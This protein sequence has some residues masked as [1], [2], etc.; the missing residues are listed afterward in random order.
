VRPVNDLSSI[1]LVSFCSWG[2]GGGAKLGGGRRGGGTEGWVI[3]K[4]LEV[5][6][7]RRRSEL[8]WKDTDSN[9]LENRCEYLSD[10][11]LVIS[12]E[13]RRPS[14]GRLECKIIGGN[15]FSN[16][17]DPRIGPLPLI[18]NLSL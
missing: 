6:D 1:L 14:D 9:P 7:P 2:I 13:L 11:S 8:D 5:R 3:E 4:R 15:G 16:R 10:V 17:S 18:D 12:L